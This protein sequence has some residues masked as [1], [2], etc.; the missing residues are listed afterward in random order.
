MKMKLTVVAVLACFVLAIAFSTQVARAAEVKKIATGSSA[1]VPAANSPE[2]KAPKED[3]P[4]RSKKKPHDD[5][6]DDDDDG[7]NGKGNDDKTKKNDGP[8]RD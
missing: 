7:D 5:K 6:D 3:K 1:I 2:V 4:K 8:H